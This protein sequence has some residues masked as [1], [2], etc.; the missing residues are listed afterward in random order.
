MIKLPIL[1][2]GNH[3]KIVG[4]VTLYTD[5]EE[6]YNKTN[7]LVLNPIVRRQASGEQEVIYFAI[8]PAPFE[9]EIVPKKRGRPKRTSIQ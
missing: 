6:I 8:Y 1:L 7:H 3:S 9:P 5:L 4:A 2:N